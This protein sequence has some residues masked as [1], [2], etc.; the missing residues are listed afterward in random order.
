MR[1]NN[2]FQEASKNGKEVNLYDFWF[3]YNSQE[4]EDYTPNP[5]YDENMTIYLFEDPVS[6]LYNRETNYRSAIVLYKGYQMTVDNDLRVSSQAVEANV[7]NIT[8]TFVNG[9]QSTTQIAQNGMPCVLKSNTWEKANHLFAGWNT[10]ENGNGTEYL[11]G[12]K[13]TFDEDITLYAHWE[14]DNFDPNN[15][16]NYDSISG[17]PAKSM[18]VWECQGDTNRCALYSEK[19]VLEELTG[20]DIDIEE[21]VAVA[22]ENNWFTED[23]GT[24][25][26]NM[27]NM[28]DCYGIE[29]EMSF[30]NSI[31]DI[32]DCLNEGGKVIV[33][34]NA[35][36]IWHGSD[37]N[38]FA[39]ESCANHAVEVIG[40][41]RTDPNNPMV[42]LN[43]S[44]SPYGKGEM[45]PLELFEGAWEVGDCQMVKCY[46]A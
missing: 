26:L 23:G 38:I 41:D 7:H 37:N 35:D 44:G 29:N 30:H 28:L 15:V 10:E 16:S 14:L 33:S 31:A 21:F 9:D 13:N 32:E 20:N 2:Y 5:N 39:P 24:T 36:E 8:I 17:D 12:S 11:D 22:K 46:K 18:E 3:M 25:F 27:N 42:I 43:D 45:I 4:L 1:V 34:I 6:A 19:F 40:V